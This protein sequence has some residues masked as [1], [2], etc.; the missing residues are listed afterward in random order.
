MNLNFYQI[1]EQHKIKKI[2]KNFLKSEKNFTKD[3]IIK[4]S[5][6]IAHMCLELINRTTDESIIFIIS[7][8]I[9]Y[10]IK[11]PNG[12]KCILNFEF[13]LKIF[14]LI[15]NKKFVFSTEGYKILCVKI[16]L[17]FIFFI[18]SI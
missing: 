12:L 15:K 10:I 4:F 6:P 9:K 16:F 11:D 18:L 5:N 8:I 14:N 2:F 17:A 1:S 3:F 13:F 7:K